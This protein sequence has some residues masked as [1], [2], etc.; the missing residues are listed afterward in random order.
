MS[1]Y[2]LRVAYGKLIRAGDDVIGQSGNMF[3]YPSRRFARFGKQLS[4]RVYPKWL[5]TYHR[6]VR[7]EGDVIGQSVNM[8]LPVMPLYSFWKK[9]S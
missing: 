7:L 9:L 2:D 6:L 4:Y 1:R 3:S 5:L 8:F